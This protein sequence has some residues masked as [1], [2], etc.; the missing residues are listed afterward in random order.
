MMETLT[1]P[2]AALC[3]LSFFRARHGTRALFKHPRKKHHVARR[4]SVNREYV[5]MA[6]RFLKQARTA[7]FRGSFLEAVNENITP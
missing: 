1:G 2:Q 7:G 4:V 5:A 6:R 3:A